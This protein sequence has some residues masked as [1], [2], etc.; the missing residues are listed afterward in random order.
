MNEPLRIVALISGNGSNLQ[1]IIEAVEQQALPARICAVIS[2]NP[3]AP[4]LDHAHAAGIPTLALD[5]KI[6]SDR[7]A[8]DAALQDAIERF[9]PQLVVL[10]GFM[11]ILGPAF[12]AHYEGRMLNIHP[13]LLPAFTGLN[14]H[15]RAL[16]A[17]ITAASGIRPP[18]MSEV[19][20]MQEHF[21][22]LPLAALTE[23]FAGA[24]PCATE[25]GAS[26]HF[27]TRE[28]DGGPVIIQARVPIL[29]SDTIKTLAQRVLNAEHCIY[30]LAIRW[31][32]EGRLQLIQGKVILD[33][34]LL[35]APVNYQHE[36]SQTQ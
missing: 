35:T 18:W 26:V 12:T 34:L 13:S 22:D 29:D 9:T 36:L 1:A 4:G 15:Q 11:R 10:A 5:H 20:K 25:H 6:F 32:A 2:N 23:P 30:P 3:H 16:E 17:R 14:T 33:G 21:F 24:L 31:F 8:F 19:S 28:L 27:V 7:T